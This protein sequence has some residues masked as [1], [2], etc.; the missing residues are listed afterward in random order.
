MVDSVYMATRNWIGEFAQT[1]S[2]APAAG[3]TCSVKAEIHAYSCYKR[4]TRTP[5][6]LWNGI[7]KLVGV[8]GYGVIHRLRVGA[9]AQLSG[10]AKDN[11]IRFE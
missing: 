8:L 11:T 7:Y 3:A 9:Y 1:E 6:Y 2:Q 5:E 4:T 10:D